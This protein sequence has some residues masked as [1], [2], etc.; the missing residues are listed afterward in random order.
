MNA[1]TVTYV[2][3]IRIDSFG[4]RGKILN[5]RYVSWFIKFSWIVSI[6][7]VIP[8]HFI[9][10]VDSEA[11]QETGSC[12]IKNVKVFFTYLLLI[13][14][15]FYI[16]PLTILLVNLIRTI[17][18][19]QGRSLFQQSVLRVE[20]KQISI[21]LISVTTFYFIFNIPYTARLLLKASGFLKNGDV[22]TTARR[23]TIFIVFL[24]T[25]TDPILYALCN[26]GFRR[27]LLHPENSE[28]NVSSTRE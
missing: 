16:T 25:L 6:A 27:G 24:T 7:F 20:R 8:M 4:H 14:I 19:I 15:L 18:H 23:S 12:E 28:Q 9:I 13:F 11:S 5:K 17:K 10:A 2:S 22:D 3:F 26:R 1:L 21:L